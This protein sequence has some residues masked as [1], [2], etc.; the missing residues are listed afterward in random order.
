MKRRGTVLPVFLLWLYLVWISVLFGAETAAA[1]PVR[2][3]E[4]AV[5]PQQTVP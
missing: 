1:I 4:P 5:T 2:V 3:P